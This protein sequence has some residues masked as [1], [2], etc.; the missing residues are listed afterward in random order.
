MIEFDRE[1]NISSR[2]FGSG[3]GTTKGRVL[4]LGMMTVYPAR[5]EAEGRAMGLRKGVCRVCKGAFV[6]ASS[7]RYSL[8]CKPC[9][10]GQ[11]ALRK[12][13]MK[14]DSAAWE[15]SQQTLELPE[16]A[17]AQVHSL[18]DFSPPPMGPDGLDDWRKERG[19]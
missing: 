3:S 1:G 19:A 14:T 10:D 15:D 13:G 9:D 4:R 11:I 5:S 17:P 18:S 16:L 2:M 8:V 6:A 12:M 7:G